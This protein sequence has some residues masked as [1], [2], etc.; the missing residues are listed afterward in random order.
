MLRIRIDGG[1]LTSRAAA[2]DRPDLGRLRPG[3][4]RRHRPAERAAALDPDRGR[5]GDLAPARGGRAAHHRGLRRLPAGDP[6]L[7][8]GRHRRR[9]DHRPDPGHPGHRRPLHRRPAVLEPAAQVQDG[10]HRPSAARRG[11]GGQR[12]RLRRRRAPRARARLRP[13]GRR[14]PVDQPDAGRTAGRLGARGGG[15]RGLGRGD[16]PVPGLRL[17]AAADPGADQVPGRR[18]GSGEVPRGAGDRV[19]EATAD[20][21][22]RP[23]DAHQVRRPR[24]GQPAEGRPVLRRAVRGRRPGQRQPAGRA[25]RPGRGARL[26]PA[27]DHADAEAAGARRRRPTRSTRWSPAP[28]R[29][30]C[31]PGRTPGGVR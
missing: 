14:R 19:P 9:R 18:L 30:G 27:A 20:R 2:G 21:R 28:R 23:G 29:S 25:G 4:R 1:A 6:R 15:R 17:P 13:L 3:H 26:D 22:S 11:A 31:R 10:D 12:H 5:A 7:A 16:R 8:G 24:R